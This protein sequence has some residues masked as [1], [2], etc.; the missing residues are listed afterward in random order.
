MKKNIVIATESE[1]PLAVTKVLVG[2]KI[3]SSLKSFEGAW[4]TS[5]ISEKSTEEGE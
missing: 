4:S 5:E 3:A 1:I 2:L